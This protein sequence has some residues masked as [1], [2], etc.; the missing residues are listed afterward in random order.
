[1]LFDYY[2]FTIHDVQTL[3]GSAEALTV[4]VV[5]G[6]VVLT[7]LINVERLDG[8]SHLVV[9]ETHHKLLC[10]CCCIRDDKVATTR[11]DTHVLSGLVELVL[12]TQHQF[13]LV[14]GIQG[15]RRVGAY[16]LDG[17]VIVTIAFPECGCR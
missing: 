8:G 15:C 14:I 16:E 1:M 9:I 4:E 11:V 17:T 5:D 7:A 6:I 3:S 13:G 12:I 10:V 2:F